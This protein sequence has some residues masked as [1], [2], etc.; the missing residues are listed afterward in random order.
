[1]LNKY[2]F[3][4]LDHTLRDL[5]RPSD[6]NSHVEPFG[7][8]VVVLGGDFRQILPVI[9]KGAQQDIL[10]ATINSSEIWSFCKVLS[11]KLT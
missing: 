2:C 11:C 6:S 4:A 9:Q 7:G 1:M 5:L 10:S 8:K 3:E